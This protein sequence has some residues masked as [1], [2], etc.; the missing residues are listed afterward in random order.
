MALRAIVPTLLGRDWWS[1][2]DYPERIMDQC[3]GTSLLDEDLLSPT[4]YRGFLIHPRT[5][6]SIATSGQSEVKNDE[7]QF[8]V[9]LNVKQFKPEEIEVKIVDN[10]VVIHGKHE[11]R[12]E[13]DGSFSTREFTRRYML[14]QNCEGD[15]VTSTLSPDGVLSILAPK[16]AIEEPPKQERKVTVN[17]DESK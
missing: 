15:T 2:W 14:P 9:S 4:L 16:K 12:N 8:Q 11:E 1:T 17:V 6:N 7:K 5:Q 10:Y 3:F 13:E